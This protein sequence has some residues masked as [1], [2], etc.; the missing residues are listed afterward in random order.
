MLWRVWG[1][2][3]WLLNFPVSS[4]EAPDSH[5]DC[6]YTPHCIRYPGEGL[7]KMSQLGREARAHCGGRERACPGTAPEAS[8]GSY[9]Q[10]PFCVQGPGDDRVPRAECLRAE[11]HWAVKRVTSKCRQSESHLLC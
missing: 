4:C 2:S 3:P 7:G 5:E 10:S 8:L 6:G 9:N 1:D 11:G